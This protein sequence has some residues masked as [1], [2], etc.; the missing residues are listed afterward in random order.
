MALCAAVFLLAPGPFA[1]AYTSLPAVVAVATSLIPIAGLFQVFDG[2][3][4]VSA[5]VLRGAGD[6]HAAMIANVLGFWLVGIP[7]S[8]WLGFSAGL[9]VVGLWLGFVAGL[10]AVAAFLVVRVRA[11]L[12]GA[13]TRM[14]VEV[15]TA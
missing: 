11:K 15:E 12:S 6:T 7:V 4:V 5:G 1:H 13:L 9:G 14:N 10:F 3:Q 8:L 2:I